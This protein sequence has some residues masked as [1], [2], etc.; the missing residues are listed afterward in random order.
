MV[1]SIRVCQGSACSSAGAA[2]LLKDIEEL[3]NGHCNVEDWGC[4]G[5]C[6][7]G[8]NAEL[9]Q[10]NGQTSIV[11][12]LTSFKNA[13]AMLTE[14]A[15]L[16]VPG[17]VRKL[18]KQKWKI[19]REEDP[20]KRAE[21]LEKAFESIGGE[22]NAKAAAEPMLLCSLLLLRAK[23]NLKSK[24]AEA[25]KDIEKAVK[26]APT[27]P[28]THLALAQICEVQGRPA[29]AVVAL[30]T[31]LDI[32]KGFNV[33]TT[34]RLLTRLERKVK[35]QPQVADAL[36]PA[37]EPAAKKAAAK[38]RSKSMGKKKASEGGADGQAKAEIATPPLPPPVEEELP[39]F[40]E[41]NLDSVSMLNHDC[42]RM[43]LTSEQQSF[44]DRQ[45][46]VGEIW[47]VDLL[48]EGEMGD[49]LKRAYTPVSTKSDYKEGNLVLMVKVYQ[50][51]KMTSYLS[52]L[53]PGNNLL[54]SAPH[55]TL[56]P[57]DYPGL[58]MIAGGSAVTVA[59]QMCKAVLMHHSHGVPVHLVLC[60]KT[61]P[62][63]L[64]VDEFDKMVR[65]FPTFHMTHCVSSGPVPAS[66]VGRQR[67]HGGR[68]SAEILAPADAS[69]KAVVSGPMGLCQASLVLW[70]RLGRAP[71]NL[72]VLDELPPPGSTL[73]EEAAAKV[74]PPPPPPLA[75]PVAPAVVRQAVAQVALPA[76][77]S[78]RP[79]AKSSSALKSVEEP[80]GLSFLQRFFTPF[81]VC[82]GRGLEED[83]MEGTTVVSVVH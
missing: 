74:A 28:Q 46:D 67:W 29:D 4:L 63:V 48:K 51:G 54:V 3:V 36:A 79:G 26:L 81:I 59:I 64:Y 37:P 65:D 33:G 45:L 16:E 39:E 62:D 32:G 17:K 41:W 73:A 71:E 1:K 13:V 66:S 27:W 60:N 82:R 30:K 18:S 42:L 49:E 35:E 50:T 69:L 14:E 19:R 47:H 78:M 12:D 57:R 20:A 52:S 53:R 22:D 9:V 24:P 80:T 11:E 56:N 75:P 38:P 83:D 10:N 40:L 68:I 61:M 72:K 8:P 34:K 70:K 76:Q 58:V 31:V 5:R 21:Q 2:P 44:R 7:L 6:G 43:V 15:E 55:P 25:L 77:E 23:E